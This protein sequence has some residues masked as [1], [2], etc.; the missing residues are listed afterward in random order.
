MAPRIY[1]LTAS[2]LCSGAA[3]ALWFFNPRS[4]GDATTV[5]RF[6]WSIYIALAAMTCAG[7]SLWG[8]AGGAVALAGLVGAYFAIWWLFDLLRLERARGAPA[9]LVPTL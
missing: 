8:A 6:T 5:V 3:V 2:F 9:V 1:W 4:F 7:A